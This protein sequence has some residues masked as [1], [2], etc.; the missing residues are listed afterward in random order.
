MIMQVWPFPPREELIEVLEWQTTVIR[1]KSAEQRIAMRS[2]PRREFNSSHT[3]TESEYSAARAM[4]RGNDVFHE[5]DWAQAVDLSSVSAGSNVVVAHADL[6]YIDFYNG[7]ALLWSS[8]D[9]YEVVQISLV[10]SDYQLEYV[11]RNYSQVLL[12]PIFGAYLPGGISA[13]RRPAILHEINASFVVY[14]NNDL[15]FSDKPQY[16]GHDVLTDCPVVAGGTFSEGLSWEY[17]VFDNMSSIP[18]FLR[19]RSV[20]DLVFQMRWHVFSAADKYELRR[21]VHSRRGRQKAFWLSSLA[22]DFTLAD[23][24]GSGD[25]TITVFKLP[26]IADLGRDEAFDIELKTL[27]GVHYYRHVTSATPG[28]PVGGVGTIQLTISSAL[29]VSVSLAQ[30]ERISF[31][32]CARFNSDRIEFS[33]RASSGTVV[34][35]PCIEV[36]VPA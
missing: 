13:S 18:E 15:G 4:V 17:S 11:S 9:N 21:W 6:P 35:V 24:I 20:P 12:M 25:V 30:I 3:L 22:H 33:H 5:P 32:R 29:G 8:V 28:S 10:G 16:R 34:Q 26:G 23:D 1:A 19:Q 2:A 31:L 27:S 36:P 7:A 14:E